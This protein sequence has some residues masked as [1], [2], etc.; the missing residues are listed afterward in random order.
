M[1]PGQVLKSIR[2][3]RGYTLDGV[4]KMVGV[5]TSAVAQWESGRTTPRRETVQ[6]LDEAL[7]ADGRIM[8]T[9][10]FT[11]LAGDP[12]TELRERV[13]RLTEAVERLTV[14]TTKQ[15]AELAQ[16]RVRRHRAAG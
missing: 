13:E 12:L 8:T 11:P 3:E 7:R 15:G 16:L 6:R 5:T 14:L 4:A 1:A 10:G 2:N 9:F